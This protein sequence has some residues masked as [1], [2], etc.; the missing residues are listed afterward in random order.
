[1]ILF[2]GK[3]LSDEKLDSVMGQLEAYCIDGISKRHDIGAIVIEAC[4]ILA[5][6]IQ[7]GEYNSILEPLLSKG[8]FSKPQMEE[9][10]AFFQGEHLRYKYQTEL[11]CLKENAGDL[12]SS[13]GVRIIR[14]Y[15]PIGILFHIAAGNAEGLPFYSVI[16]G[17]L[18]GNINILKLPSA[19]DG[20]SIL[21]LHELVQLQP[22]LAAYICVLDIPSTNLGVMKQLA[23][24]ADGVVV[25]GSDGAIQAVRNLASPETQI[26]SWGHKLSFAY[27]AGKAEEKDLQALARHICET[28]QLLCSSCQGIFVDSDDEAEVVEFGKRFLAI[29]EKESERYPE[30]A[31]GIRGKAAI[32]LYNEELEAQVTQRK[33]LRGRG[34]SVIV[35]MEQELE[36]SHMFRNCWVRPLPRAEII[37]TLKRKKGHLQ[38]V[39]LICR[40][41]ERLELAELFVK[42]GVVRV[43]LAGDMSRTVSGE[44]HDGEYP[45][46]RYS[47][48]VEITTTIS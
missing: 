36:L 37:E 35:S 34:V 46:R 18:A 44:A 32:A 31:I 23:A 41:E 8:I 33:V 25:W 43:N 28:R 22:E 48:V 26:I 15:E 30:E 6:R 20:L 11:G 45:L 27:V 5:D 2:N 12:M 24:L 1:M 13:S 47:R 3:L 39:G 9:A 21:L 4:D 17:L 40:E 29:L 7:K 10:I 38:T 19:D 16:E 42:A 14:K